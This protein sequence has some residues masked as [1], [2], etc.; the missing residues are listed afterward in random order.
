MGR[1][2]N[3][4]I[5]TIGVLAV[6]GYLIYTKTD[7]F[8]QMFTAIKD[9]VADV[10]G[11]VKSGG[12]RGGGSVGQGNLSASGAQTIFPATGKKWTAKDSGK[13]TRNYASGKASTGTTEWNATGVGAVTN[14]ES[15]LLVN[16]G[17]CS[18]TVSIKHY[19]PT[20]SGSN[21]CFLIMDVECDT[22]KFMLG[23]EGPH[24]TTESSN[25]GTGGSMGSI[26]N[27]EV[28][29]KLVTYKSGSGFTAIAYGNTGSGWKEY[30]RKSFTEFGAKKKASSPHANSQVQF[31]TDCS[32]VKY[33]VA[34]VAEINPTGAGAGAAAAAASA[35]ATVESKKASSK[36]TTYYS[37]GQFSNNLFTKNK[38]LPVGYYTVRN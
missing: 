26:K 35:P 27:K 7:W 30:I 23:G 5:L 34:E 8:Q 17:S 9:I 6:G 13:K 1:G 31:R 37:S 14:I 25:L 3:D 38:R 33:S 11:G 36:Y 12:G 22:G 18:D 21:C 32:G 20:H 28:G 15:T 29:I 2:F 16:V 10:K 24:P 19:G 4:D